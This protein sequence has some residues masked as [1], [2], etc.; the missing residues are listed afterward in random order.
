MLIRHG[1]N[2]KNSKIKEGVRIGNRAFS[3]M[4]INLDLM[5]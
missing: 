2:K 4:L 1:I 5:P 3:G